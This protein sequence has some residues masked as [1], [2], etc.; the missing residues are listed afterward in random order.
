VRRVRS[1][2]AL[3]IGLALTVVY[4]GYRVVAL[5]QRLDAV[6]AQL[7]GPS[8]SNAT[9]KPAPTAVA[10][11]AGPKPARPP[12]Q[13]L[14][15]RLAQLEHELVSLRADVRSL[16]AATES[17]LNQPPADPKQ[18]LSVVGSEVSRIRD[19]HLEFQHAQWLKMRRAGLAQFATDQALSDQQRAELDDLLSDE[20]D[21][22]LELLRR[23]D[24]ADKPEELASEARAALRDTDEAARGVLDHM[25]Y[26][27]WMQIR[28][29]ERR[30]LWPFLPE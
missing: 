23:E 26:V 21:R 22:W 24:L 2:L 17:T 9:G 13:G 14:E 19:K 29:V 1:L 25:Q 7:G 18:I 10:Q 8:K 15:P 6:N 3:A 27:R 12:V 20:L 16:E 28:A 11:A 4:L 5:E 30:V